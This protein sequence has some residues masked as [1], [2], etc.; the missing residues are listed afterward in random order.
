MAKPFNQIDPNLLPQGIRSSFMDNVNG[1]TM[2]FLESGYRSPDRP[3]ILL[4]HGFSE[5]AYSWRKIMLPLA[6]VGYHV[7][8]PDQRG[9]GRTTGWDSDYD[10]DLASFQLF[11]LVRD[12][13]A[14]LSALGYSSVKSVVGH[15][16]GSSVAAYC[17]LIRPDIFQSVALMGA[18][19]AGAPEFPWPDADNLMGKADKVLIAESLLNLSPARKYYRHY[20]CTR[21]A[22][23]DM[24]N[25][26]QGLSKFLRA[27]FHYK[28]ANWPGNQPF[29]LTSWDA[30]ELAEMLTYYIMRANL[31]MPESVAPFLPDESN[32]YSCNWLNDSE[33]QFYVEEYSR[34]G[35]QGGLQWYRCSYEKDQIHSLWI[36]AG[37]KLNM[38]SCFMAGQSDW[39]TYQSPGAF[40]K[41]QSEVCTHMTVC[42]LIP[43]AGH[44]LQQEQPKAVQKII[45]MLVS[46]L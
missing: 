46:E 13:V 35:F 36:Y 9:F 42:E 12:R 39:G 16:F 24:L 38:P 37:C 18:P 32:K 41:M 44:W 20:H 19:F 1:L 8:A 14:L 17:A 5:R 25:S 2:H 29:P 7:I 21:T 30:S 22:N 34:T 15:D 4:L 27:Y 43:G 45:L 11:N 3:V 28:S 40:E 33:L 23:W 31:T 10:G 26:A 6:E